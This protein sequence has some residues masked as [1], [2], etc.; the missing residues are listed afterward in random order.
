MLPKRWSN[1]CHFLASAN[2]SL[3]S[4]KSATKTSKA[5]EYHEQADT[6]AD[7]SREIIKYKTFD[8]KIFIS[9]TERKG[10]CDLYIGRL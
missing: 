9:C 3:V 1:N 2:E 6:G 5:L 10:G 4:L 8:P 7:H